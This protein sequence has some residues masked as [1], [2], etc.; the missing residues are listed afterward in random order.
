MAQKSG[1]NPILAAWL[2]NIFFG[3]FAT[4]LL[5]KAKR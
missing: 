1:F 4:Y 5:N 2:P 3:I